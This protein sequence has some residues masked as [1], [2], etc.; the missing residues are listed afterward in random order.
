MASEPEFYLEPGKMLGRQ[1]KIVEFLGNGFEGEVYKVEE[2][3]TGII[4]AAKLFYKH[5]YSRKHLPH[6]T[7]AKKL[8]AL[9]SCSIIIQYHHHD[10]VRIKGE[11][12]DFLVSEFVDGVVLADWIKKSPQKRILPFEALHLFYSLVQGVEQIHF[13]GE[14]H[15]DIHANNIIVKRKGLHF[16]VNLIDLFHLGKSNRLRIKDDVIDL[17]DVFYQMIG[18]QKYYKTMPKYIKRIIL[19]KN[20]NLI[21]KR[22]KTAGHLRL[23][24]ENLDLE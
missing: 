4:R 12:V 13:L 19:G 8:N 22:F 14:Y 3:S 15:G 20:S 5:R 24:I 16:D 11:P 9:H 23:F 21:E 2:V 1:Y 7:Y 18:G 6:V 10:M 17:I